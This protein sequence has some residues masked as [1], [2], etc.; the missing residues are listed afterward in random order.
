MRW[1]RVQMWSSSWMIRKTDAGFGAALD[2]VCCKSVFDKVLWKKWSERSIWRFLL[3]NPY[4][5]IGMYV[6][7]YCIVICGSSGVVLG[8]HRIRAGFRYVLVGKYE[9]GLLLGTTK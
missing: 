1:H 8:R 7:H 5:V 2:G 9:I 6:R 4:L 3:L